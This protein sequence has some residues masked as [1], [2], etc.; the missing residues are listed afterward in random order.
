[1][2]PHLVT[3]FGNLFSTRRSRVS[4]TSLVLVTSIVPLSEMAVLHLF[5]SLI[6]EGPGSFG[7]DP[8][9]VLA[10]V[11]L[12]FLA[13][14]V[15]RV[16]H[17]FVRFR[18]LKVF[19]VAFDDRGRQ[20]SPSEQSWDWAIAFELSGILVSLV[21]VVTFSALFF[22]IDRP[23]GLVNVIVC[24]AVLG[25]MSL[26]YGRQLA[27]QQDYVSAGGGS[28]TIP[29]SERV[30]T[31]VRDAEL[32]A[33]LATGGM[34][35]VLTVMMFRTL[36]GVLDSAQAIMLFLGL[37][38]LS[39]QLATLSAGSMRFARAWARGGAK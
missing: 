38:L 31:R 12:F 15:T 7:A 37:R 13:F 9:S 14:G 1:M 18:R 2:L 21:H 29:V 27:L 28:G 16:T 8:S 35:L 11:G 17:H 36:D 4:V 10:K 32:G 5:S 39:G 22:V 25:L 34:I 24:G 6:I 33:V 19:R 3:A 26:L 23:L 20:R 30:R